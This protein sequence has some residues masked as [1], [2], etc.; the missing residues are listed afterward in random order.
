MKAPNQVIA[1]Q[2]RLMAAKKARQERSR[3]LVRSGQKS[4]KSMFLIHSSIF[5]E[6]KVTHRVLS[7]D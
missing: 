2:S 3:T 6:I 4:Q 1:Q 7:F 5:E